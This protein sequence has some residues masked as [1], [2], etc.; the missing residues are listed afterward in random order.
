MQGCAAVT[1]AADRLLC[2]H[3]AGTWHFTGRVI[4]MEH[5]GMEMSYR[6]GQFERG[7]SQKT[8]RQTQL[9]MQMHNYRNPYFTPDAFQTP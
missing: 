2:G 6:V 3:S 1:N 5:N 7:A 8:L 9:V 4:M